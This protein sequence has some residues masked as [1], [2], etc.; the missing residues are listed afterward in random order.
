MH[1]KIIYIV[2]FFTMTAAQG[3]EHWHNGAQMSDRR[4]GMSAV[5]L[6]NK[7]W[8]IGG[9]RN[10]HQAVNTVEI[11]DPQNDVWLSNGPSLRQARDNATAQVVANRIYVFGG[12]KMHTVYDDVEMLD[13]Q[14]G[15]WQ[16]VSKM[17]SALFGMAS[18]VVD[19]TIWLIGG[20]FSNN[21]FSDRVYIYNPSK[22]EWSTLAANLNIARGS[23]MAAAFRDTVYVF[24]GFYFGPLTS[25]ERYNPDTGA[26]ILEGD[27][28][29]AAAGCGYAQSEKNVWLFGGMGQNGLMK[30]SQTFS[31]QAASPWQSGPALTEPKQ[32]LVYYDGKVYAFGGRGGMMGGASDQMEIL[33]VATAVNRHKTQPPVDF[34]LLQNYPNP[35]RESTTFRIRLPRHDKIALVMYN[36]LGRQVA[37]IYEGQ[38]TAGEHQIPFATQ[39]NLKDLP[40]GIYLVRMVGEQFSQTI[41][42]NLLR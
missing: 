19:S 40:S 14:S 23:P 36:L 28:L 16:V 10:E 39:L 4:K 8:V 38:L 6:E 17:P 41:K 30:T 35:F 31:W 12:R 11:Y 13:P 29:Y 32:E 15:Q 21:S 24:G 34:A 26:W 25:Y 22:N 2:L 18:V 5:V 1:I 20:S 37:R 7:I 9:A 3:Q 27:M 42:I 33:D